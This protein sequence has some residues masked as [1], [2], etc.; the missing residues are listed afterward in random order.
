MAISKSPPS[1][2]SIE[3]CHRGHKP[4]VNVR[5]DAL[6]STSI[7]NIGCLAYAFTNVNFVGFRETAI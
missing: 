5:D 6:T 4:G 7:S 3:A 1:I 2:H